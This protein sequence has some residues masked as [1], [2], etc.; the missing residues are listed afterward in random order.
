[1]IGHF[2]LDNAENNDTAMEIIGGELGFV[3]KAR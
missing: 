3:A 2:M 1:M